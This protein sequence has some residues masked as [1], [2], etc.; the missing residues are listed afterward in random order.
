MQEIPYMGG[1]FYIGWALPWT[2][3]NQGRTV[4]NNMVREELNATYQHRPLITADEVTGTKIDIIPPV[5][6]TSHPGRL[7]ETHT[8][9]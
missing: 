8:I 3:K 6:R 2:L 5:F 4:N 7:L 9:Y 1:V